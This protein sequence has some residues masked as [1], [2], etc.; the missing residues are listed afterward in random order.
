[1]DNNTVRAIDGTSSN[2]AFSR[3]VIWR[4]ALKAGID[5]MNMASAPANSWLDAIKGLIK[6]GATKAAEVEWSGISDW[7][8]LQSGKVTKAQ[9]GEYLGANGVQVQE[10]V[11]GGKSGQEQRDALQAE[12]DEKTKSF[13]DKVEPS[14]VIDG[15]KYYTDEL[16]Y[17]LADGELS[18]NSLPS[19]LHQRRKQSG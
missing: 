6:K 5:A 8:E 12:T 17:E 14:I 16:Y 11:L 7:L 4:S 18:I 2:I 3:N 10:V 15:K 9:I 19:D 13:F 1:M